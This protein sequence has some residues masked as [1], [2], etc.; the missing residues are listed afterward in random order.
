ME[1]E[2]YRRHAEVEASHWWFV[3]RK[4]IIRQILS[5]LKLPQSAEILEIGCGTGGNIPMLSAFGHVTAFDKS[6]EAEK[7]VKEQYAVPMLRGSFPEDENLLSNGRFDLIVLLDVLEHLKDD[8]E[9]LGAI[10]RLLK[11]NGKLVLT[12]PAYSWLWGEHDIICQHYRRYSKKQMEQRLKKSG[13]AIQKISYFNTILFPIIAGVRLHRN[14]LQTKH[15]DED[16]VIPSPRIN[17]WLTQVFSA[18]RYLLPHS[19]LP[20]GISLLAV[21]TAS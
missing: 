14:L 15:K 11:P 7:S 1:Q 13:L 4:N 10:K 17:H 2:L 5:S 20:F 6:P 18:E 12:V 19:N 21:A 3:A 8:L 9:A 16:L